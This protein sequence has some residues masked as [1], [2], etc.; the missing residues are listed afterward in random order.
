[1][2]DFDNFISRQV[3]IVL[4]ESA[5]E[6]EKTTPLEKLDVAL[7]V[8]GSKDHTGAMEAYFAPYQ[9]L[10]NLFKLA[11]AGLKLVANDIVFS[12]KKTLAIRP[13]SWAAANEA[14]EKRMA[15][16]N[17]DW[18][19]ALK[20]TGADTG[21]ASVISF[22]AFPAPFVAS[23]MVSQGVKTAASVNHGLIDVGIRLPLVQ[24]ILPGSTPPDE[25]DMSPEELDRKKRGEL[26]TKDGIKAA[27]LAL[28]FAHH[29]KPGT[30]LVEQP[31]KQIKITNDSV[32][33]HLKEMGFIEE[34]NKQLKEIFEKKKE[35]IERFQKDENFAEKF[36]DVGVILKVKTYEELVAATQDVKD[37]SLKKLVEDYVKK[38]EEQ[39]QKVMKDKKF[40]QKAESEI[41][42]SALREDPSN[43]NEKQEALKKQAL[44]SV[45]SATHEQVIKEISEG[46]AEYARWVFESI[47]SIY[48]VDKKSMKNP[49]VKKFV[50][51]KNEILDKLINYI[52]V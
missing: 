40:Q 11:V 38:V 10:R 17:K 41:S 7:E 2:K 39:S 30:V 15:K 37:S 13:S 31:E 44:N 18:E 52:S 23:T 25:L 8:L 26:S 28:F 21:A 3:S 1:M 36:Q 5:E 20:A 24:S 4:K 27:L 16:L 32:E 49:I 42:E 33:S 6:E 9:A 50:E 12:I 45:F 22:L 48:K 47:E 34:A 51:E 46:T 35:A 14:H 29:E 43:S 19:G